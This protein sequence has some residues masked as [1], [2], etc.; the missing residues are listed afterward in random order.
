MPE[1]WQKQDGSNTHTYT[2]NTDII[3]QSG[4]ATSDKCKCNSKTQHQ[5]TIVNT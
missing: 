1:M 4:N 3:R 5:E 2:E